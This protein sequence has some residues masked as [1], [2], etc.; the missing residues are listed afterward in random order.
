MFRNRNE[1]WEKVAY[2]IYNWTVLL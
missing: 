2:T 1:R